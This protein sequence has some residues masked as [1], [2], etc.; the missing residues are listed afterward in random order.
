M[1]RSRS[2]TS[3]WVPGEWMPPR[4][5]PQDEVGVVEAGARHFI[6]CLLGEETPVLTAEHARHVLEIILKAYDSIADGR[7][8]DIE[9]TFGGQPWAG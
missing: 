3:R 5:A 6:A 4:D 8:H 9:T 1:R 7:S 2:L